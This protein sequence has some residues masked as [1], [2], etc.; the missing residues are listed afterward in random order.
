MKSGKGGEIIWT[1]IQYKDYTN[2]VPFET[3]SYQWTLNDPQPKLAFDIKDTNSQL[4]FEIG[5]QVILHDENTPGSSSEAAIPGVNLARNIINLADT[6][7]WS[8]AGTNAALVVTPGNATMHLTFSN[9][10]VG[11]GYLQQ[12]TAPGIIQAGLSYMFSAYITGSGSPTNIQ[13][14]LQINW[15]DAGNN[16][17]SSI[18]GQANAPGTQTRLNISG[19]A[20]TNAYAAQ[21]WLGA[22]STNSTNSGTITISTVQFE[23]MTF[24]DQGVS[25]PTPDNNFNQVICNILPDKSCARATRIYAGTFDDMQVE[26]DGPS[27]VWHMSVVGTGFIME[28]QSG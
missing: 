21:I 6:A 14:L 22:V 24:V 27:R 20:P 17:I 5:Q 15:L 9:S 25:Y 13:Y 4:S 16:V 1:E 19:A 11:A 28:N 23:P 8:A 2:L 10:P 3:I 18:T 12:S 7:N 26:Y